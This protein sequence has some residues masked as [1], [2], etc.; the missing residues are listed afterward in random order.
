MYSCTSQQ[1]LGNISISYRDLL[2]DCH[3]V[4]SGAGQKIAST[5]WPQKL[6]APK[7][8]AILECDR[9][10]Q[11]SAIL[12]AIDRGYKTSPLRFGWRQGQASENHGDL[13]LRFLVLFG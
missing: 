3:C 12:L 6:L 9:K 11:A 10:S 8:L 4:F 7:I 2:C 1:G 13:R 5:F